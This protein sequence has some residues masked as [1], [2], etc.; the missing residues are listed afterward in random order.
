MS[1]SKD[2]GNSMRALVGAARLGSLSLIATRC[3]LGVLH[4]VICFLTSDS[5]GKE[6][7][8]PLAFLAAAGSDPFLRSLSWPRLAAP[9]VFPVSAADGA[10]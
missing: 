9:V 1:L 8:V 10:N 2:H 6:I 3:P 7:Y 4:P 5:A